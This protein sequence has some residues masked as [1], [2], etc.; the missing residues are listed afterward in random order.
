MKSGLITIVGRPNAGKSTLTN[1][2]CGAKVAIV[3]N[4]PQTTRN[5]I[6][7]VAYY[8]DVQLVLMDTPGFH[9]PKNKLDDVMQRTVNESMLDV[10]ALVLVV[11]PVAR[12]GKPEGILLE[13][14]KAMGVPCVLV[15]NKIDTLPRQ[16]LLSVLQLYAE[17][18]D[19]TAMIPLSAR[20]GN[21]VDALKQELAKLMPEGPQLFPDGM[22]T[23]QPDQQYACEIVREKLLWA[24]NQEIPHGIAC[25]CEQWEESAGLLSIG[26]TIVCERE[27]HKSIVIGKQGSVL[28]KVGEQARIELEKFFNCKVFLETWVK[29][30]KNWRDS[31][32]H[33]RS[34]G[35]TVE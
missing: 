13:R 18:Y 8:D 33:V 7:A 35:Y 4:K 30:R 23:D 31:Q 16:E 9:K 6:S 17:Q 5:R 21:G 20:T 25:V 34:Y 32:A 11:E 19:F 10:D 15:I 26:V 12:I 2:L 24:L 29:V 3:S 14:I 22:V 1:T 27:S 28:K